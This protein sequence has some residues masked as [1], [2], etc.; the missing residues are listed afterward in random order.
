MGGCF[1]FLD[2]AITGSKCLKPAGISKIA[3]GIYTPLKKIVTNPDVLG[4]LINYCSLCSP[5]DTQY[6]AI[7]M[8]RR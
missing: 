8:E 2:N 5:Y 6:Y 3:Q 1:F 4:D 7:F